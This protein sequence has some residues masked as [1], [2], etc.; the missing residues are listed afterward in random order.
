[1]RYKSIFQ[2]EHNSYYC[3]FC[4]NYATQWHH[5]FNASNKK[6]SEEYGLML[7]LCNGCHMK[8]HE[9]MMYQMKRF[10]QTQCMDFYNMSISDFRE[11]FGKNYL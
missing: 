3:Y 4:G 11:I 6:H 1:M 2:N 7:H 9:K 8:V 10:A 5:I